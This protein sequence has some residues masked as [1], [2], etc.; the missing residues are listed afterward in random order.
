MALTTEFTVKIKKS[1][2]ETLLMISIGFRTLLNSDYQ[3]I[4]YICEQLINW[5]VKK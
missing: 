3:I 5:K 2:D 4:N 1:L